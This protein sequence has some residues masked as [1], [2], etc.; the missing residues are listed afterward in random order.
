MTPRFRPQAIKAEAPR[1]TGA[2]WLSWKRAHLLTASALAA[3]AESPVRKKE[4][5]IRRYFI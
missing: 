3:A 2:T 4:E 1:D 5:D